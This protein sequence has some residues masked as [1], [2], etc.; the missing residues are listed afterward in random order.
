[1]NGVTG[2]F[3]SVMLPH[4]SHF[5]ICYWVSVR[6]CFKQRNV[7]GVWVS[8]NGKRIRALRPKVIHT[9][10]YRSMPILV[11]QSEKRIQDN[12]GLE[13]LLVTQIIKIF[14]K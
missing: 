6:S 10:S 5:F 4:I 12:H 9:I 13:K 3:N 8:S 7:K 2:L 11:I 14:Y 1:M